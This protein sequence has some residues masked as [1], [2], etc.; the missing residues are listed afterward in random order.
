MA[1]EVTFVRFGHSKGGIIG[2]TTKPKTF[3]VWVYST[4]SCTKIK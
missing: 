1:I 3:K 2:I 4:F